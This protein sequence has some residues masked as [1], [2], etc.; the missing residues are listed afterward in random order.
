M[1]EDPAVVDVSTLDLD[2]EEVLTFWFEDLEKAD[3]LEKRTEV[4]MSRMPFWYGEKRSSMKASI[5]E[6]FGKYVD[7]LAADIE[8]HGDRD[9]ATDKDTKRAPFI[10]RAT[11]SARDALVMVLIGDQL[12]RVMFKGT[13]KC[14]MFDP[15]IVT[16]VKLGMEKGWDKELFAISPT[17]AHFFW[18]PLWHIEVLEDNKLAAEIYRTWIPEHLPDDHPFLMERAKREVC[19]WYDMHVRFGRIIWLDYLRGRETTDEELEALRKDKDTFEPMQDHFSA[20]LQMKIWGSVKK[21]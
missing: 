11:A 5:T 12:Q 15:R 3:S 7:A 20:E 6:R 2:P 1:A 16:L 21:R 14:L 9:L 8:E 17:F 18:S 13:S 10:A 4:L 19:L